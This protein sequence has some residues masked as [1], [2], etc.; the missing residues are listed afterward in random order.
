MWPRITDELGRDMFGSKCITGWRVIA[1][2]FPSPHRGASLFRR[3]AKALQLF[4]VKRREAEKGKLEESSVGCE[5]M[6]SCSGSTAHGLSRTGKEG[7]RMGRRRRRIQG[8]GGHEDIGLA[9]RAPQSALQL[10][11]SALLADGKNSRDFRTLCNLTIII[12]TSI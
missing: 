6:W 12:T 5:D 7:G 10:A 9:A 1:F 11:G 2:C 8:V 3:E 4:W